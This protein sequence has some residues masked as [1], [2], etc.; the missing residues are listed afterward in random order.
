LL[1][2]FCNIL[3]GWPLQAEFLVNFRNALPAEGQ[4]ARLHRVEEVLPPK[5]HEIYQPLLRQDHVNDVLAMQGKSL[6]VRELS[7]L[8]ASQHFSKSIIRDCLRLVAEL[9]TVL[10]WYLRPQQL[11]TFFEA[12]DEVSSDFTFFA[13]RETVTAQDDSPRANLIHFAS[14]RELLTF[15]AETE[16]EPVS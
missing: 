13:L 7:S 10:L 11:L 1:R 3:I 15:L 6:L 12:L 16:A 9:V 2:R 14:D 5:T 8:Q 4:N